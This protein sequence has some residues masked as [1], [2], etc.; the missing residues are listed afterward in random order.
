VKKTAANP[1]EGDIR[2]LSDIQ[3][4]Q[5]RVFTY[6]DA[7]SS[8]VQNFSS[9]SLVQGKRPSPKSNDFG[10]GFL[11]FIRTHWSLMLANDQ[12]RF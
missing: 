1:G 10:D 12:M 3:K 7:R 6:V 9:D 8:C 4:F 5:R 2:H 11:L